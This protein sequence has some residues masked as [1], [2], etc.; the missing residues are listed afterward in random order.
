M[1]EGSN[2]QLAAAALAAAV[3]ISKFTVFF[4]SLLFRPERKGLNPHRS[5]IIVA[6]LI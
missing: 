4:I 6:A 3:E 5:L 2:C 1:A